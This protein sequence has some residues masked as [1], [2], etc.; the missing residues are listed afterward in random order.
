MM[1]SRPLLAALA[2]AMMLSAGASHAEGIA[3]NA[4]HVR[5]S[6]QGAS[7][8]LRHPS[9]SL[10]RARVIDGAQRLIQALQNDDVEIFLQLTL[11]RLIDLI[12]GREAFAE[13]Y[14]KGMEGIREAGIVTE[15]YVYSETFPLV[16]RKKEVYAAIPTTMVMRSPSTGRIVVE[17]CLIAFSADEGRTWKYINGHERFSRRSE[18]KKLLPDVPK[19]L[20]LPKYKRTIDGD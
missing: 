15:S 3:L 18:L 4:H 11:P 5:L 12:G 16:R 8:A 9:D 2:A 6:A 19:S 13:L 7:R 20:K 10:A 17:S 1:I 14:R